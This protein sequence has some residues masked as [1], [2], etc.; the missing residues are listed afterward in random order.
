MGGWSTQRAVYLFPGYRGRRPVVRC[1]WS[2]RICCALEGHY[3][4]YICGSSLKR[5]KTSSTEKVMHMVCG[6][7]IDRWEPASVQV[8]SEDWLIV[9]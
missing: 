1:K 9:S 2:G 5:A 7:R 8:G 4:D 3:F 6:S